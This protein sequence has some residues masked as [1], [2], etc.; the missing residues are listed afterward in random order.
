VQ[1]PAPEP[2]AAPLRLLQISDPHLFA[3]PAGRLLGI[4]TRDAL[5]Q[6]LAQIRQRHGTPDL[7]LVT[8]DLVHDGSASGY[9]WLQQRLAGTAGT[10]LYLPGNH[11]LPEVM[12]TVLGW[13]RD[14]P[15]TTLRRGNWS[16][17]LLDS[18]IPDAA[19][20]HLS[21]ATLEHLEQCLGEDRQQQR[22]TLVALHHNPVPMGS[23]W[24]DT[25][26]VDNPDP[27]FGLLDRAPGVRALLWGHVHQ[28]CDGARDGLQLLA[29]PSTCVQFAPGAERFTLDQTPPGYRWL[30]L[31]PQGRL[32]TGI[33]RL[34]AFRGTP[35]PDIDG[36]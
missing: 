14:G 10:V 16:L 8:G 30:H 27:L 28:A 18:T 12:A 5:E 29:C 1:P 15:V 25:M 31:Y 13:G 3:S 19:G 35:D 20:G 32:E 26:T 11:D 22:H 2:A 24:L 36:Y 17:L 7:L 33:E 9:H 6:T 4:V 21:E 34:E 23:T